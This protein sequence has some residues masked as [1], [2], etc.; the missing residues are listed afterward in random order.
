MELSACLRLDALQTGIVLKAAAERRALRDHLG[1]D[2]LLVHKHGEGGEA[3]QRGLD[4]RS[5][6][7]DVHY[8]A[9]LKDSR[10]AAT[11]Y[12]RQKVAHCLRVVRIGLIV[13]RQSDNKHD[14]VHIVKAVDPLSALRLLPTHIHHSAMTIQ[15]VFVF[16]AK[17]PKLLRNEQ[18]VEA[19]VG[20]V[21]LV[22]ASRL[23]A[24]LHNVLLRRLVAVGADAHRVVEKT[25]EFQQ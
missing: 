8:E 25:E 11:Q 20:K 13:L 2:V 6:D 9:I 3:E 16:S 24:A 4:D 12:G 23:P 1:E 15:L 17:T 5:K 14:Q 10:A 21:D 18:E 22:D 7:L 19:L